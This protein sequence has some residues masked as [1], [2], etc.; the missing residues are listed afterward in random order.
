M[1][2]SHRVDHHVRCRTGQNWNES[3]IILNF[4][5]VLIGFQKGD[6]ILRLGRLLAVMVLC[7][8]ARSVE[9]QDRKVKIW[10]KILVL[11]KSFGS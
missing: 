2:E 8:L 9:H 1:L 3:E 6:V 5:I 10:Q 7:Y 4:I 11:T